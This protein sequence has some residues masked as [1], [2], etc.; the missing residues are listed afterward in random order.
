VDEK[1]YD[2]LA[3]LI[4][5]AANEPDIAIEELKG[6]DGRGIR[7]IRINQDQDLIIRLDD[8]TTINAGKLPKGEPG[9]KGEKGEPGRDGLSISGKDGI[10]GLAGKDGRDVREINSNADGNLIFT[11]SDGEQIFVK[12]PESKTGG[13]KRWGGGGTT[14]VYVDAAIL[15]ATQ[16][17]VHTIVAGSNISVDSTDPANPIVSAS[18]L[19]S[20]TLTN[21][22]ILVGNA[23][24]IATDVALSGDA[25]LA[26][27]GAI[28]LATVNSTVGSFGS[29]YVIPTITVN[30][31]GLITAVNSNFVVAPAGTLTGSTLASG[32]TA[33]SLTSF[34]NSPSF[35]T[36]LL[37]TPTSG[38]LTNCTGLPLTTGITGILPIAN[39]G[40]NTN[41]QTSFG[42]CYYDGTK[43]TTSPYATINFIAGDI[44][45]LITHPSV[46]GTVYE[47]LVTSSSSQY[48]MSYNTA[49]TFQ[50][51][52]GTAATEN[53]WT[54]STK[55]L[56]LSVS[57]VALWFGSTSNDDLSFYRNNTER[58]RLTT[59]GI[60]VPDVAYLSAASPTINAMGSGTSL[61][62]T[63]VRLISAYNASG[64]G[65]NQYFLGSGNDGGL[66]QV[67]GCAGTIA[68]PTAITTGGRLGGFFGRGYA[69]TGYS[70]AITAIEY[71]AESTFS[72]TSTPSYI[73]ISTCASSAT[74]RREILRINSAGSLLFADGNT[75]AI[76][77]RGS[78]GSYSIQYYNDG[79]RYPL[80]FVGASDAG[81]PRWF[82]F[83]N[84][85]SDTYGGTW[86]AKVSINSATAYTTIGTV[87][88]GPW[89]VSTTYALFGNTALDQTN[90]GNYS[91]VVSAGGELNLNRPTSQN[92]YMRENNG[93]TSQLTVLTGGKVGINVN[94]P[95]NYLDAWNNANSAGYNEVAR[96]VVTNNSFG[97][98]YSRLLVG[99]NSTNAMFIDC[100]NQSN[101]KGNLLLQP[102]GGFVG[103]GLTVPEDL[104]H[105]ARS[106]SGGIGGRIVLDNTATLATGN[107]C[108]IA[109]LT[110]SGASISSYNA[111]IKAVQDGSGFGYTAL[112]FGTFGGAGVPDERVRITPAGNVGINTGAT[113]SRKLTVQGSS[114]SND[115][116][117]YLKQSNDYGYSFNLDS[118]STGRLWIK[119]VNNGIE[120]DIMT[121]DRTNGYVGIGTTAPS[122]RLVVN[123]NAGYSSRAANPLPA[124][125]AVQSGAS[126]YL[127]LGN[128]Y[129]GGVGTCS[130]IQSTDF[131]SGSDHG[132]N[133]LLNPLGG[134]V[135]IGEDTPNFTLV[136]RYTG[137]AAQISARYNGTS[138]SNAKELLIGYD[139]PSGDGFGWIQGVANGISYTPLVLQRYGGNVGM[140]GIPTSTGGYNTKLDIYNGGT[141]PCIKIQDSSGS[142]RGHIQIG[143]SSTA[144]NNVHIG[145][146][147]NGAFYV[148]NGTFG[149]GAQKFVVD[150]SG[151][152]STNNTTTLN[153]YIATGVSGAYVQLGNSNSGGYSTQLIHSGIH[154]IFQNG[155]GGAMYFRTY[156]ANYAA[157]VGEMILGQEGALYIANRASVPGTLAGGGSIYVESGALKYKGSSGTVTTIA[158]A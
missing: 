38:T 103:I 90:A 115:L 71:Y 141:G 81:T 32:V 86:N 88:T 26:N 40:T 139:I 27:T 138:A 12:L 21:T 142:G 30:A 63:N 73:T 75:D 20:T 78:I 52:C 124:Q 11:M 85:T 62:Q 96:F 151:N 137:S 13:A 25:T 57:A 121:L 135:G 15:A 47:V 146:E 107:A 89:P 35:V 69:T 50:G 74:T 83:G 46:T 61:I 108:E 4:Q 77:F 29:S 123:E 31:K 64:A 19:V 109:F 114:S 111:N 119:G 10:D 51:I 7:N 65:T 101:T 39:G 9:E 94:S 125:V 33:S 5:K 136:A 120:T 82:E 3:Y 131:F 93:A 44:D 112:T 49:S 155:A 91:I 106:T 42:M 53:Y 48:I 97:T 1:L 79:S 129:T 45:L 18:G 66:L 116:M 156:T 105:I 118:F 41:T 102:F 55:G 68:S 84:Y 144:A 152:M 98:N 56:G 92:I 23:S 67:F 150:A 147:G 104:L 60:Y 157:V 2:I 6:K 54:L 143:S 128:Y 34:G 8:N 122:W 100:A 24:N 149:S 148:W 132:C 95:A 134:N 80:R 36:P 58:L 127:R 14:K 22:H 153:A 72:D 130:T 110:D 99:Q 16:D 87:A 117:F 158:A 133:L 76:G 28:T 17:L 145:C 59:T 154:S 37:G 126:G 140:S 113:V 43:L 70:N